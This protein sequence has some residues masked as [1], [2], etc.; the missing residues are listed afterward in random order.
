MESNYPEVSIS[1]TAA[2]EFACKVTAVTTVYNKETCR[3]EMCD[4]SNRGYFN[5]R[6]H[7]WYSALLTTS[8]FLTCRVVHE[9]DV[10]VLGLTDHW[11]TLTP[12]WTRDI[13]VCSST[14]ELPRWSLFFFFLQTPPPPHTCT[15]CSPKCLTACDSI[16]IPPCILIYQAVISPYR[17]YS[18]TIQCVFFPW[19]H[20]HASSSRLHQTCTTTKLCTDVCRLRT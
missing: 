20:M 7:A 16:F 1:L 11:L 17:L 3:F 18:L 2:S 13:S 14:A 5:C 6:Q 4:W 15:S 12:F 19:I 9:P 8:R 10:A